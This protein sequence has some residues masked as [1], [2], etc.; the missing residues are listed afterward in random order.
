MRQRFY[1]LG[2]LHSHQRKRQEKAMT[3][4]DRTVDSEELELLFGIPFKI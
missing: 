1:A 2:A 4:D 3:N